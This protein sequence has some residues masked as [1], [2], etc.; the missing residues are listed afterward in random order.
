VGGAGASAVPPRKNVSDDADPDAEA[1][2]AGWDINLK[3]KLPDYR[4]RQVR[5][6][7]RILQLAFGSGFKCNS[8]LLLRL[9]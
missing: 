6:G 1:A 9:R 3:W 4:G 8:S 7:D 2:A 5:R